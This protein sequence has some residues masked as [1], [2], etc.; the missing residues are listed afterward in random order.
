MKNHEVSFHNIPIEYMTI[1]L[2]WQ[3]FHNFYI[4]VFHWKSKE[5]IFAIIS[6][7]LILVGDHNT[8]ISIN[9]QT[10]ILFNTTEADSHSFFLNQTL[11]I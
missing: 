5:N 1:K 3:D 7:A 8:G 9:V 2:V 10:C 11:H 4:M 6:Y